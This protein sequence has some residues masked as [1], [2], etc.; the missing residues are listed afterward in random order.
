MYYPQS[1]SR[2]IGKEIFLLYNLNFLGITNFILTFNSGPCFKW[3]W[4]Y[5]RCGLPVVFQN[6]HSEGMLT[7]VK[8]KDLHM[9][10]LNNIDHH[11]MNEEGFV[12]LILTF[13]GEAL[14]S[15]WLWQTTPSLICIIS[16]YHTQ[17]CP[18]I[19]SLLI[20]N[21]SKKTGQIDLVIKRRIYLVVTGWGVFLSEI[22]CY[23]FLIKL[24]QPLL[25]TRHLKV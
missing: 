25:N 11:L 5:P 10:M 2:Q 15:L 22:L 23:W 18:V 16:S 12:C 21:F 20:I 17:P 1:F 6:R 3:W 13:G 9:Y 24:V 7:S 19:F 4:T 8:A 14:F